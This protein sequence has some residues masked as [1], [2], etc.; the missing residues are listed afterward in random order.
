MTLSHS[1]YRLLASSVVALFISA[2]TAQPIIFVSQGGTQDLCN[3]S[4]FDSGYLQNYGPGES[5]VITFCPG[6]PGAVTQVAFNSFDLG[7]GDQ[8]VIHDG[9]SNAAPVLETGTSNSLSGLV[10]IATTGC[11]TFEFMSD[12]SGESTGWDAQILCD[13]P[14][15]EPVAVITPLADD[16]LKLCPGAAVAFDAAGSYP[17]AGN[18]IVE[19]TWELGDGTTATGPQVSNTYTAPGQY[20]I[21]LRVS[22]Q[23]GCASVNYASA[24]IQVGTPPDLSGVTA[25]PTSFCAGESGAISGAV[26]GTEWTNLPEPF[27]EGL[28]QLPDGG[29]VSYNAQVSVSGFPPGTSITDASDLAEICFEME[30]S[31]LGDLEFELT[32]PNGQTVTLFN[33]NDGGGGG[34]YL[35][36]ADDTGTGVPGVGAFYC[37]SDVGAFGT[38]VDEFQNGN[39]VN[40]GTPPN[41][42]M[43]PGSYTSEESFNSL[44]GCDVNGTWT[45]TI[46]DH[47]FIDDGYIFSWYM[48]FDPSLYPTLV[49]FTPVY[50]AGCDSTFWSGPFITAQQP[51]CD[52]I[53]VQPP[54]A[55][56][57]DYTYTAIDDFGCVYDTTISITVTPAASI[58]VTSELPAACGDPVQL[59]ASLIPP[60]PVGPIAYQ[61]TPAVG[62]NNANIPQP[63]ASPAVPT[64]YSVYVVPVGHPLCADRDSVL[65]NPLT[66]LEN[67]SVVIDALCFEDGSGSIQIISTGNGGPWDYVWTDENGVVVRTTF[68]SVG[69]TYVGSGGN[70]TVVVS[71]GINGNGCEDSLTAFINQPPPMEMLFLS[72]DTLI[73]RTG[74]ATLQALAQGGSGTLTYH[75]NNGATVAPLLVSPIDTTTYAVWATD[76]NNCTSDTLSTTVEVRPL[77][78][79]ELIDSVTSCPDV[80]VVFSPDTIGGGD[81]QYT[82]DWGDGPGIAPDLVVNTNTSQQFCLTLRDGCETPAVTRCVWLNSLPIPDLIVTVD[83]ALGCDPFFTLFHI[84]DTTG[85]ALAQWN[86]GDG[87]L[88]PGP[89]TT[90]GHTYTDPGIYDITAV[91]QWPN[92]CYDT[93]VVAEMVNVAHVPIAEFSW[94]PNPISVLSPTAQFIEQ[95]DQYAVDFQWEF[96]S[97]DTASGPVTEYTFPSQAGGTYPV[98]LVVSN[99]LG[100]TDTILRLVEVEDE[101]LVFIPNAFTPDA[102]GLNDEVSVQGD[103]IDPEAFT[104]QIFDRWGRVVHESNDRWGSWDGTYNGALVPVGVYNWRLQARSAYTGEPYRILGH[105]TV[106]R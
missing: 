93:T 18:S 101:F 25:Q 11:L 100:C 17:A 69:D 76:P 81:G 8:L 70:Y 91:V 44:V 47:L 50:G 87:A 29:G 102:D 38:M 63:Q 42:S 36:G 71:E 14:C 43:T 34:T 35:G 20:L 46:T 30:H 83:S 80:T 64:W 54:T 24:V 88:V 16:P 27:V 7:A 56:N 74:A 26:V 104:W 1:L 59:I 37:F 28:V 31:F 6:L 79:L 32:C 60:A 4:F 62:L 40:A 73:C 13:Q 23:I 89:V 75:W 78:E 99:Y 77:L 9:P 51:G 53:T 49:A 94:V 92:G 39:F 52:N 103:D 2:L 48:Q 5:F 90:V 21:T 55:G 67:D 97:D 96:L 3:A 58:D 57:Y 22:D 45:I 85:G 19:Y 15:P 86:F 12:G 66:T 98:Q 68:T 82:Y 95:S 105:L 61:W 106:V 41:N 72:D 33:T 10:V 84:E 65:V